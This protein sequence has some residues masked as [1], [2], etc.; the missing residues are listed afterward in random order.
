MLFKQFHTLYCHVRSAY[1]CLELD[2]TS[3]SGAGFPLLVHRTIA[4]QIHL[5]EEIGKGR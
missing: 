2:L 1:Y 3:G 4:R 5:L